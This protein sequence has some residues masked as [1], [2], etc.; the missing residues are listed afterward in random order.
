MSEFF[1]REDE[2]IE[3]LQLNGLRLIQKKQGFRF[4]MDTVLLADFARIR[5]TDTVADFGTGTGILPFL[6]HG[7][8]KGAY[9]YA[10]ERLP[11]MAEM[12][13]RSIRLNHLQ[14][15]I[16]LIC[17]DVRTL[18]GQI[19]ERS[20]DAVICNP[21]YGLPGH[22]LHNPDLLRNAARHQEENTLDAF[23]CQARNLLKG[24]GK[25][26]L[27]YPA[28]QMLQLM[29]RLQ[30]FRIE[31]KRFRLVYP[32]MDHPANL[33]LVE[34]VKDAKPLLHP[35]PPLILYEADGRLTKE[36]RSVYHMAEQTKVCH[37]E[38]LP[39]PPGIIKPSG[40]DIPGLHKEEKP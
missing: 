9:Y 18:S 31:P 21:P 34:A 2:T 27:V 30:K 40:G 11:E 6:L 22:T 29:T 20:L 8:K 14:D 19:P 12:A 36:L 23:I 25:L 37:S 26:I 1:C 16:Q 13:G 10:I 17:E 32:F 39:H 4:G 35:M 33:V 24:K 15:R 3:D 5:P 28:A 38:T 7:R